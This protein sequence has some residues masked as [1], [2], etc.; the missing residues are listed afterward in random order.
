MSNNDGG[1][2]GG[3]KPGRPKDSGYRG[4]EKFYGKCD[5][6]LSR[7]ELSMLERLSDLNGVSKSDVMRRAL[8]DYF[9]FNAEE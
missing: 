2:G 7:K 9:K 6:R 4:Q 5:V 3:R 1:R 8:R